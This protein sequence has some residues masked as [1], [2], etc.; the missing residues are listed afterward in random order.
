VLVGIVSPLFSKETTSDTRQ[1]A[2][3][4]VLST[5]DFIFDLAALIGSEASL[6][7]TNLQTINWRHLSFFL[8]FEAPLCCLFFIVVAYKLKED[9]LVSSLQL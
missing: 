9:A 3:A 5:S 2:F 6:V 4:F 8:E 1:R 7:H